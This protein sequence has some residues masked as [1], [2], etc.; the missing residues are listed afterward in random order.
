M[1]RVQQLF[2]IAL[3]SLIAFS[4]STDLPG[5]VTNSNLVSQ[6]QATL[7][8]QIDQHILNTVRETRKAF[9][10]NDAENDL[11]FDA[12]Q[13]SE[14][15]L[16]V[17]YNTVM[18][19]RIA[20]NE[21][22]D[23]VYESEGI[24]K[25]SNAVEDPILRYENLQLG[26]IHV[27]INE[28]ETLE[29]LR[30]HEQTLFVEVRGYPF[31]FNLAFE[32]AP[33]TTFERTASSDENFRSMVLDPMSDVPYPDQVS[34]IDGGLRTVMRRHNMEPAYVEHGVFGDDIGLAIIDNGL[35]PDRTDFFYDNGYGDRYQSGY[36]NPLWFFPWT[37]PDGDQPRPTDVFG[38]SQLF[39]DTYYIH[40]SEM[41]KMGVTLAP[42]AN[43][44]AVRGSTWTV[45]VTPGQAI[46]I[47]NA[48]MAAADDPTVDVISMSM[49][50]II[51]F[52]EIRLAIEYF[53][54]KGKMFVCSAGSTADIINDLLGVLYPGILPETVVA[55][56]MQNREST[57]GEFIVGSGSHGGP[58]NDF[59][60]ENS[61]SSSVACSRAAGMITLI[62]SANPELTRDEL[63]DVLIRA[64]HFFQENGQKDPFF[65]WGPIDVGLAVEL[66]MAE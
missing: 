40:G 45:I 33:V 66:A 9:N 34:A 57:N 13:I 43:I 41:M 24:K 19:G 59:A 55:T 23:I 49:G 36:Y 6:D 10:W 16:I 48:I 47:A 50:T 42:N 51:Q 20:K 3:L 31:D 5:P 8:E 12:L 60:V 26:V 22:L 58:E 32:D 56:A 7:K 14:G 2:L 65:G 15:V 52:N 30:E 61:N 39:Y 17:G 29:K 28:M 37:N 62:W 46:G 35:L 54:S 11:L 38:I 44:H 1:N 4:C 25:E 53:H 63:M 18:D 27:A 21:I 64:S